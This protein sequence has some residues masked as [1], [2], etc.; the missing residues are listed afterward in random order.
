MC[1][2]I[3]E[4]GTTYN[5]DTD[6]QFDAKSVVEYKLKQRLDFR[7]IKSVQVLKGVIGDKNSKY[8]N[9]GNQFDGSELYCTSGWSYKWR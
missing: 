7:R 3:L 5:I 6:S 1:I 9:S 4:D 8:Y 2:V